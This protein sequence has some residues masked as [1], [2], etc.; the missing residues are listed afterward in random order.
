MNT[1]NKS[2]EVK[3][4][5]TIP[6]RQ[7][8][9]INLQLHDWSYKKRTML[10]LVIMALL[11]GFFTGSIFALEIVI[12]GLGFKDRIS[13]TLTRA[14]IDWNGL[15]YLYEKSIILLFLS[16]SSLTGL[17]IWISI[18]DSLIEKD[19]RSKKITKGGKKNR[20][21][22]FS[23]VTAVIGVGIFFVPLIPRQCF[24]KYVA[25]ELRRQYISK[26]TEVNSLLYIWHSYGLYK[27]PVIILCDSWY[28]SKTIIKSC[29][30]LGFILI[31][32]LKSNRNLNKKRIDN[33]RCGLRKNQSTKYSDDKN[34]FLL[35]LRVG[36][37]NGIKEQIKVLFSHRTNKSKRIQTWKYIFCTTNNFDSILI[38]NWY[39][40]RWAVETFHQIWEDIFH[41]KK[42]SFQCPDRIQNLATLSIIAITFSIEYY[43]KKHSNYYDVSTIKL[44]KCIMAIAL[45][46]SKIELISRKGVNIPL[47]N[48]LL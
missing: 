45:N 4:N 19:N 29:I 39:Q 36:T 18:D 38:L 2:T 7:W 12:L 33:L 16:I 9:Y 5:K 27:V 13:Y 24:R 8:L 15:I 42:W 35:Y 41:V 25:D 17:S 44:E 28:S 40:K 11:S 34:D 21:E 32:S 22:G 47:I 46:N 31:G 20:I 3:Y 23:F 30:K 14:K 26:T 37:L 6:I 1:T 43:V 48:K 10:A